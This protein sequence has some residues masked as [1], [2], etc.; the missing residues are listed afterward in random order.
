VLLPGIVGRWTDISE[1][2]VPMIVVSS[3]PG[4]MWAPNI[5]RLTGAVYGSTSARKL[6]LMDWTDPFSREAA[7]PIS[8]A[9][10]PGAVPRRNPYRRI[11]YV[12]RLSA[13][14]P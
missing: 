10:N 3:I 2:A 7:A 13:F 5:R 6:Q 1:N 11:R 4:L 9:A 14:P 12:G 8:C